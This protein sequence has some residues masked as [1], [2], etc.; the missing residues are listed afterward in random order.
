MC[1]SDL[2]PSP[3]DGTP[4][5]VAPNP[6]SLAVPQVQSDQGPR[7]TDSEG[8]RTGD[9][10]AVLRATNTARMRAEMLHRGLRLYRTAACMNQQS[11]GEC[12]IA[13]NSDGYLFR[14]LGGE[15]GWQQLGKAPSLETEILIGP[16]GKTVSRILY[17]GA[18]RG[19]SSASVPGVPRPTTI[20]P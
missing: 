4:A 17:N 6:P 9:V 3:M 16:D 11:G 12:L 19:R 14:F 5:P 8:A 10:N 18:P 7:T 13:V 15:P 1:S 2:A 20:T